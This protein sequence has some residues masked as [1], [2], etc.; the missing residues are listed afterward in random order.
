MRLRVR[1][2][3]GSPVTI[4]EVAL[5][6][7]GEGLAATRT[8]TNVPGGNIDA[9]AS[10]EL[11]DLVVS[12]QSHQ[13]DAAK[14]FVATVTYRKA[15][16]ETWAATGTAAIPDCARMFYV[17]APWPSV[18]AVGQSVEMTGGLMLCPVNWF[19]LHRTQIQWRSL[20]PQIARVDPTGIVTGVSS[21]IAT[22]QGTYGNMVKSH[23]VTVS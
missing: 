4:S 14:S 10:V 2:T 18:I 12:D 23:M 7:V 19:V 21:G 1:E 8:F 13:L 15:S 5:Q 6:F 3:A 22:I 11:N 16:G 9:G 17:G 20:D